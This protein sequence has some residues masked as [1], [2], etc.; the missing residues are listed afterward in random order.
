MQDQSLQAI[1]TDVEKEL[2]LSIV[3]NIKDKRLTEQAGRRLAR[4]FLDL[5]PMQD[6]EDLLQKLLLFSKKHV[7]AKQ[8]Y[9]KVAK[10][11]EEEAQLK[12]I[13]MISQHIQAGNIEHAITVAKGGNVQ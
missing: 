6:K 10:P 3:R 12:K 4:E 7:E 5:L 2:L 13:D 9:V 11:Y 8:A 1:V